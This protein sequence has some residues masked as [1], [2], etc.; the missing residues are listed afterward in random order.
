MFEERPSLWL[1]NAQRGGKCVYV[2][3]VIVTLAQGSG[4][5]GLRTG[6]TFGGGRNMQE[7]GLKLTFSTATC[8]GAG[9]WLESMGSVPRV[10]H[11]TL[12]SV[13]CAF[14]AP[15]NADFPSTN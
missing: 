13:S 15:S 3:A 7:G 10:P 6:G 8:A 4:L 5:T 9:M 1:N 14:A 12:G 11:L 2:G